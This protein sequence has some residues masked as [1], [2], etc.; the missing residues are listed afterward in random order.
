MKVW[1]RLDLV[2]SN[3]T[4]GNLLGRYVDLQSDCTTWVGTQTWELL[5]CTLSRETGSWLSDLD[6]HIVLTEVITR[7]PNS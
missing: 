3:Q 4:N 2:L 5:F 6:P 7:N 1:G